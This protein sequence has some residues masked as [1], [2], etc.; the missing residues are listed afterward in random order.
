MKRIL[1]L[2][3]TQ[4]NIIP[5]I[6][7][8]KMPNYAYYYPRNNSKNY[9]KRVIAGYH[10]VDSKNI[11]LGNGSSEIIDAITLIY[12]SNTLIFAPTFFQYLYY[13]NKYMY[14]PVIE[15]WKWHNGE[16]TYSNDSYRKYSLIWICTPNNP[17][18]DEVYDSTIITMAKNVNGII[19]VDES[20]LL[21]E[22]PFPKLK[23]QEV[24]NINNIISIRS[25]SKTFGIPGLRLGYCIGDEKLISNIEKCFEPY[26]INA[27]AI[28]WGIECVKNK[29]KFSKILKSQ[30]ELRNTIVNRLSDMGYC[31]R[32]NNSNFITIK[33]KSIY[34]CRNIIKYLKKENIYLSPIWDWEFTSKKYP[35]IRLG[36]PLENDVSYLLNAFLEYKENICL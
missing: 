6:L 25:F 31:I 4:L 36:I 26:H 17:T 9:L 19:A 10:D 5:K 18:G 1:D 7:S 14:K 30:I 12:G 2:R 21:V 13:Q 11:Y 22:D 20:C 32:L 35:Y 3:H 34:E 28:Y 23:Y 33:M 24:S 27:S 15:Y 29:N 16:I 8:N